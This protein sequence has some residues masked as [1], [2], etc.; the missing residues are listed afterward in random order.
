MNNIKAFA[1]MS[2]LSILLVLLGSAVGG[3]NGAAIF[4]LISLGMNLFSYYY[5]DK[6]VIKMT[7]AQEIEESKAPQIYAMIRKLTS[8]AGMPMPKI[9]VTPSMQPNAFA[10]G[11]NPEHSAVAVTQGLLG[12]L[13][14]DELEGVLA[15]EIAHIKNR[16]ILI[17]TM[18]A[19]IAG[20]IAMIANVAQWGLMFGG[21]GGSDD[22]DGGGILGTVVMALLAPIAAMIIQMAISRSREYGADET[23]AFL[24]GN[25]QGLS[26]ALLKLQA[27]SQRVPMEISPGVAHMFIINPLA[28]FSLASLFST[29]PPVEQR[30]AKLKLFR[31]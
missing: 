24:A 10:T 30:V 13:D 26:S 6:M 8:R 15:H 16:D 1:L 5:S 20:A 22:D 27:A 2:G 3:T 21:F 29:H 11:R 19:S 12:I 23:G 7:K 4:F 28:G 17:G 18:A 14:Q 31:S 9:Y 25:P